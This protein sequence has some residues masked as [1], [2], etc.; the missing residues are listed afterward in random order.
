[1]L[2]HAFRQKFLGELGVSNVISWQRT[3]PHS[4][5]AQRLRCQKWLFYNPP[6]CPREFNQHQANHSDFPNVQAIEN[7]VLDS[8]GS[9]QLIFCA[10]TKF[11]HFWQKLHNPICFF[12]LMN[13]WIV[14]CSPRP[15]PAIFA[16]LWLLAKISLR[17]KMCGLCNV[18]AL[19]WVEFPNSGLQFIL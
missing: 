7:R 5:Q 9:S 2:F 4:T 6:L 12:W 19:E 1:M 13:L 8:L 14:L 15:P 10:S 18:N 11:S 16:A 3:H 17:K